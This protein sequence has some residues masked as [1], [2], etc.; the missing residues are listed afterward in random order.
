MSLKAVMKTPGEEFNNKAVH[1]T[2]NVRNSTVHHGP[3]K[4]PSSE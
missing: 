3:N 2:G 4:S 1:K